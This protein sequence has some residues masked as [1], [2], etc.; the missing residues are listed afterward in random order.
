MGRVGVG[1][2]SAVVSIVGT[3]LRAGLALTSCE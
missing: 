1:G 3:A 2:S